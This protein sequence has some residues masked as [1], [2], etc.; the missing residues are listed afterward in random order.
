MDKIH[1]TYT[2]RR[3]ES[4]DDAKQLHDL[5]NQVFYPEEVGVFADTIFHHFP[6]MKKEYWFIAEEKKTN[7]IVSGFVLLPWTWVFEGIHL[8]VAEMGIVGTHKEHRGKGIMKIL[9][10]EFD[11]TLKEQG[12]HL[13]V[14][15]GIA[16]FYHQF[17]YFYSVPLENHINL[18][19]HLIPGKQGDTSYTFRYAEER[20]IPFLMGEDTIY[21]SHFSLACLRSE[22]VWKYLLVESRKTIYGSE[23]WIMEQ[24][25]HGEKIYFRIPN[26]GFGAGLIVSEC[27]EQITLEAM[28]SLLVFCKEKAIERNKPYIR[29]NLHNESTLGKMVIYIAGGKGGTP[30]AW[31]IKI[32]D[33]SRILTT[34]SPILEKRIKASCFT[35][36][37]GKLRLDFFKTKL[38]CTWKN[39]M[40]KTVTRGEGE[41]E[42]ILYIKADLFPPLCLGYRTRLE[43]RTN[44]PDIFTNSHKSALLVD[45]LFPGIKSWIHEQY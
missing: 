14:I 10:S 19:L 11:A 29:L 41:S 6:G 12:F 9:N 26:S 44:R 31:Q 13:A 4:T 40:L 42:Y 16:G 8:K 43:L 3:A 2:M 39:G 23:F 38:D 22:S 1:Q 28:E 5:F 18:S 32:P 17:G 25:N 37:S 45:T 30:Y 24:K 20:D 7:H 33:F 34:I 21:R 15:Q 36:F 35:N 27:S